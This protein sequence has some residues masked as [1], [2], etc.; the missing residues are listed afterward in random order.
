MTQLLDTELTPSYTK[1]YPN[2]PDC[3]ECLNATE[4]LMLPAEEP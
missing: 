4:T 2:G 3:G 1:S